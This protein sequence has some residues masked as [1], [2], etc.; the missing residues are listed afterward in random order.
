MGDLLKAFHR[1]LYGSLGDNN[2][3]KSNIKNFSG[4]EDADNEAAMVN[5]K[6]KLIA[7]KVW[8]MPALKE[9]STLLGQE[10]SGTKEQ[11]IDRIMNFLAIPSKE[12]M[13][14][15]LADKDALKKKKQEAAAKKKSQSSER[16]RKD[17]K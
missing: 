7:A 16:E 11:V 2:K 12:K 13:T 3:R 4:F 14:K 9:R 17:K 8:T 10:K 6:G 5:R 15:V 1:L